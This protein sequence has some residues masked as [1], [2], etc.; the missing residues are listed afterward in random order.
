MRRTLLGTVLV[1]FFRVFWTKDR[2]VWL[3]PP[4]LLPVG[5]FWWTAIYVSK[6]SKQFQLNKV[7]TAFAINAALS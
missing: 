3:T 2:T 7:V 4:Y 1:K 5:I 6:R